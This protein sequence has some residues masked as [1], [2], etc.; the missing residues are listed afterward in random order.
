MAA[1]NS[2]LTY[3]SLNRI[4]KKDHYPLP[5]LSDL[6]DAPKKAQVFTKIDLHHAYHLVRIADGE[7]WK[8]TFRTCYGSFKWLVMPFSLTNTPAAFQRFMN[9]IFSDLLD[10]CVIIHLDDILIYS[11]D[12]SQHKAHVKEVLHRLWKNG[13]YAVA[14][15]CEF[16]KE[17]VEYLGF[18]LSTDG[19]CMAQ[20]KVQ[21]ILDWL[22][23][24]KVKH[25]QSF[26][27]F[28]NFYRRFIHSYSDIVIPLT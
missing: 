17:S 8:T 15:K 13:L 26:L 3:H 22:E 24:R 5:L 4:T 6:L 12:M 21:T 16:H 10:V 7:E 11:E 19:L 9:D 28:C 14:L 1:Y 25:V 2:V 20:D 23:P 18:I 27:G